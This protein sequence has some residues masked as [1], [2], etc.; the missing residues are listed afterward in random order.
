MALLKKREVP[1]YLFKGFLDS[2]KTTFIR[3]TVEEGQ[4]EDGR[5]TLLIYCEEGEEEL[6]DALLKKNKFIVETVD[7]EEAV[8]TALFA[9]FEKT[10]KPDRVIIETNGMWDAMELIQALPEEWLI[11]EIITTVDSTTFES[12][13]ANMKMMM[14]NQFKDADLIL[15]NRCRDDHDRA[16]F[17]RMVRAVNRMGQVLFE[18]TDGQVSDDAHEEPPY[19]INAEIIE[20]NDDDFG[21]FYLDALDNLENFKGKTVRFKGQVLHPKKAKEDVFVPGRYA[22]TCCAE[23]IAFVGFPCRYDEAAFLKNKDWIF[24]T[25]KIGS[26]PSREMGG[27][28]PVLFAKKIEPAQPAAEEIVYFN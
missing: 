1:V 14:T 3:E 2:G 20:V 24:V 9:G 27:E 15:F 7:D 16:M 5:K 13:L 25:A 28:A 4:F 6:S 8:D 19:D 17:K 11:A 22:M 23:D 12:Y 26:A 21:I 10:Y 18:T